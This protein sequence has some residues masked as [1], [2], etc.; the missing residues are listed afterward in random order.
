MKRWWCG[1]GHA[2]LFLP[3]AC[4]G[5]LETGIAGSRAAAAAAVGGAAPGMANVVSGGASTAPASSAPLGPGEDLLPMSA[6]DEQALAGSA[7]MGI[8]MEY[9]LGP[10]SL[11]F[12][13][14]LGQSMAR[15]SP[16]GIDTNWQPTQTALLG[17]LARIPSSWLVGLSFY[18][19]RA[20]QPNFGGPL[21]ATA[22]LATDWNVAIDMLGSPGS[23]QYAAIERAILGAK[24]HPNAGTP[25]ED[26]YLA[27]LSAIEARPSTRAVVLVT[28]GQPTLAAG[29]TGSG[30][31]TDRV[32]TDPIVQD[33]SAAAA[34]NVMTVIIGTPGSARTASGEDSRPWLSQAARA[35]GTVRC[36]TCDANEYCHIDMTSA[37]DPVEAFADRL[38]VVAYRPPPCSYTVPTPPPAATLDLDAVSLIYYGS[39]GLSLVRQ[40]TTEPCQ[41][42]WHFLPGREQ[43]EICDGTC[44][45]IQCDPQARVELLFGCAEHPTL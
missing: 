3:L 14:D 43:I 38:A 25:T 4:G 13:V 20:T 16:N 31:P 44:Q 42:G 19:N 33:I 6:Q 24:P 9:E 39:G 35:G 40:N 27:A 28:E 23:A 5:R 18:P 2:A 26:A 29:C 41:Y 37:L 36:G 22:C 30:A 21:P 32:A 17:M 11:E 8:S 12:V 34:R 7:C 15:L 1:L 10:V 45:K